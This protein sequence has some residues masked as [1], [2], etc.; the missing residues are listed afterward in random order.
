M[1]QTAEPG[2]GCDT[3][4]RIRTLLDFTTGRCFLRQR[5]MSS[6]LMIVTDVLI[7]QAFQMML[8][9]NDDVVELQSVPV[10]CQP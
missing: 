9:H 8:I 10:V 5:K 6:I 4:P 1:V 3:A 7:H 2:N